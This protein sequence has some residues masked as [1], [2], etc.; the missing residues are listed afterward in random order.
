MWRHS[1][2]LKV[3]YDNLNLNI[4]NLKA[5]SE[6]IKQADKAS[7]SVLEIKWNNNHLQWT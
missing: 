3:K 6:A 5:V 4:E 2:C 1:Y 7:M